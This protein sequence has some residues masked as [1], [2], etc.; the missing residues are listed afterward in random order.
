[1][2]KFKDYLIFVTPINQSLI[3]FKQKH[4]KTYKKNRGHHTAVKIT[5]ETK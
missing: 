5:A 3:G 4:K 2:M 1:M